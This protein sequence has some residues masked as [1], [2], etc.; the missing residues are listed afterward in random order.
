MRTTGLLSGLAKHHDSRVDV[1]NTLL[2]YT[3]MA[4]DGAR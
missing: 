1:I 2:P 3:Q 4:L